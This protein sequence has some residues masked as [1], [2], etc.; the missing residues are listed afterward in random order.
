MY[1]VLSGKDSVKIDVSID[2]DD[3]LKL[4]IG[5]FVAVLFASIVAKSIKL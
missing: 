4:I 5:V 1:D 3:L 2:N